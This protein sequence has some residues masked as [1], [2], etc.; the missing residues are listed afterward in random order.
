MFQLPS[1]NQLPQVYLYVL[2]LFTLKNAHQ[3]GQLTL[4]V[5][6]RFPSPAHAT[7]VVYGLLLFPFAVV[8]V[9]KSIKGVRNGTGGFV[10]ALTAGF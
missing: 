4:N 3:F 5:I 10:I 8:C 9:D 7:S 1:F 2:Y 6:N